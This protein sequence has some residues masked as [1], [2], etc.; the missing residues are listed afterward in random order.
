MRV[1]AIGLACACSFG[2]AT[3]H[4][5]GDDTSG[6][7]LSIDPPTSELLI[8]NGAPASEP[9]TATLTAPDGTTQDVTTM[10]QFS[11]DISYG[12]F[13]DATLTMTSGGKT[14]VMA[15]Y[16]VDKVA[17]AQVIAR[18]KDIR[19]D[20]NV[21]S[22]APDWF[23]MPEDPTHAPTIVY[24]PADIVM[25][26]NLG[27]FEVHW[28]DASTNDV[29]EVSLTTEFT[30]VRLY[31]PGGNGTYAAL[32][33]DPSWAEFLANEWQ[34]AVSTETALSFQVRGVQSS[35]PVSVGSAPAE[36]VQVTN[37]PM[38]GGIYYWSAAGTASPEGIYRHDM[39]SPGVPAE[40]YITD[41]QTS[42]RCVACHVLSRDG[43][44]M[45]I[46]W[47]GGGAPADMIDV[48]T[49][50]YQG[51][52]NRWNFGTFSPDGS[53]FLSI[54]SGTLTVRNYADQSVLTTM[55]SAGWVTHPDLSPDG[56]QLVYVRPDGD[57]VRLELRRRPD[58]HSHVRCSF[59]IVRPRDAAVREHAE[60]LLSVVLARRPVDPVQPVDRQQHQW[61][62]LEPELD[63][64]GDEGRRQLPADRA[65]GG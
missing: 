31:V 27:D 11:V 14:I 63:G 42:G 30:D 7:T 9:F 6:D 46:T 25:P 62:V 24:P 36:S 44:E 60:Q 5:T 55:T 22:N 33:P 15:T 50:A 29:F 45:A 37:E 26:R 8:V 39:G 21:A 10:V 16:G 32:G 23:S 35:N 47:D 40:Q 4:S 12:M 51:K 3:H 2:C 53:Q 19:I 58:L 38:L 28:R 20:P 13:T 48:G 49:K 65:R 17:N 43:H 34:D 56:T 64:V 52:T 61:C 1:R 57:P 18:M 54:E 41:N 59:D